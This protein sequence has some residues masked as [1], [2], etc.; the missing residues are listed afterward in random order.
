MDDG[1]PGAGSAPTRLLVIRHGESTWNAE[2]RWQGHAD[3]PL[4]ARGREQARTAATRLGDVDQLWCS[5]LAR[6]RVTAELVAPAGTA[7]RVEPRLR[8]RHVGAWAGLTSDEIEAAHPGWLRDGRRPAG[9]EDDAA[10]CG[11]VWP[12]LLELVTS[13][14]P[15]GCAVTVTHGGV[16][17]TLLLRLGGVTRP[18][19]NLGGMWLHADAGGLALGA[20]VALLSDEQPTEA[21]SAVD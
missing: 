14:R 6:A 1:A 19:P 13:T 18:V 3:P 10:V 8:E 2:R 11:R 21:R 15:G 20:G 17:R 9:W 5:D 4:S 7:L 16:I 12:A